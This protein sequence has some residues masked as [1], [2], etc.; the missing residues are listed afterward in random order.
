MDPGKAPP[1]LLLV[2]VLVLGLGALVVWIHVFALFL[3]GMKEIFEG[4]VGPMNLC[5]LFCHALGF[6]CF[7]S[8]T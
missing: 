2:D 8:S 3:D 4:S 7:R 1:L 5:Y 6:T